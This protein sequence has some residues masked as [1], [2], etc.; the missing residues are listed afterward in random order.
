MRTHSARVVLGVLLLSATAAC[1]DIDSSDDDDDTT[2]TTVAPEDTTSTAPDATTTTADGA[3]ALG[4][5]PPFHEDG[6]SGS[7]CTPGDGS[8]L[9][10]GWWYG[11]VAGPP[12]GSVTFD[13]ACYYSGAAAEDIAASRG[14][15]VT[16]D[17]YVV[18][19]NDAVRTLAVGSGATA[20]CV[21]LG[22][23]LT[24]VDCPP[25]DVD[26]EWAVWVRVQ[27]GTVDRI[28]EQYAP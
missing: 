20:T 26:G 18:N 2:T 23:Q 11:L 1:I 12:T 6:P 14:D 17:Y 22:S 15:E 5:E 21:E 4:D 13:L 16:N 19:D 24:M 7:G 10:D 3:A 25:A 9:P 28:V 8:E 27:G